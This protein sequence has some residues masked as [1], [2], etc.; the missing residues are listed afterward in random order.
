MSDLAIVIVSYNTRDLLRACLESIYRSEGDFSLQVCVVDNASSDGSGEMVR[1]QFPQVSLISSASN[2]GYAF[3]N[4]L[5]L[6]WLGFEGHGSEQCPLPSA[7]AV[8]SEEALPTPPQTPPRFVLLLNPDTLLPPNALR[9]MLAFMEARPRAGVAG[10]KLVRPDGSLD[11][12]CRRSFPTPTVSCYHM[13]G[14]SRLFPRS[15]RFGRYNM[16]YMDPD[17]VTQLDS[18]VGAFMM[19]RSEAIRQAGLLDETFFMYG[20][21]LDWAYRIKQEGWQVWYNPAV[22]V[23]HIKEAASRH[24]ER[25]RREFYHAMNLFYHKH[26][27]AETPI[28]LHYTIVGGIALRG[29][30]ELAGRNLREQARVLK[31]R[32]R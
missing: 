13:I 4:N 3:A 17:Q 19:V 32:L 21:D 26:Y 7:A 10:P 18:V 6:R 8:S 9:E 12:A 24:S 30:W 29:G 31:G 20:E 1:D 27:R 28:W 11:R 2:G 16:T 22:T 23:L 14:L 5:A 15:P 25:A